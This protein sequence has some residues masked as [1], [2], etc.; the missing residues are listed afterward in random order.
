[1]KEREDG[2]L[3]YKANNRTN[4]R[5]LDSYKLVNLLIEQKE[6]LLTE[7]SAEVIK[8]HISIPLDAEKVYDYDIEQ[9]CR[10]VPSDVKDPQDKDAVNIMFDSET[11]NNKKRKHIPYLASYICDKDNSKNTLTGKDCLDQMLMELAENTEVQVSRKR[12]S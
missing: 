11:Y 6:K 7:V 12:Q 5:F 1:M 8:A 2:H 3:F 10:P 4:D 9:H